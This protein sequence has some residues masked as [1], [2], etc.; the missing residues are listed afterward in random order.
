MKRETARDE[1]PVRCS[2]CGAWWWQRPNTRPAKCPHCRSALWVIP[3][4]T[5]SGSL[6]C[7]RCGY[8]WTP[9]AAAHPVKCPRCHSPSWNMPTATYHCF[10]CNHVWQPRDGHAPAKCPGCNNALTRRLV[11]FGSIAA[12]RKTDAYKKIS[13]IFKRVRRRARRTR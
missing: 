1:K 5:R 11:W 7:K 8:E 12:Y 9:R 4:E 10:R 13:R 2:A 6:Q 3:M